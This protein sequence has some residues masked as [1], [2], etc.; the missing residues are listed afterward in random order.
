[1]ATKE[2]IFNLMKQY[3]KFDEMFMKAVAA[4]NKAEA[5]DIKLQM[6]KIRE[7]LASL[8]EVAQPPQDEQP[9]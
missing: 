8:G 7:Q 2:A 5:E 3:T 4:D 1:M 9:S 6:G